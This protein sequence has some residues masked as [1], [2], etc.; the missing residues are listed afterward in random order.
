MLEK[1]RKLP[2]KIKVTTA[3]TLILSALLIVFCI[4]FLAHVIEFKLMAYFV[5]P[6]MAVILI[7]GTIRDFSR[8]RTVAIFN[9]LVSLF[10]IGASIFIFTRK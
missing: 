10:I 6:S 8:S 1:F 4:L 9:L 5:F 3:G 2:T 7:L